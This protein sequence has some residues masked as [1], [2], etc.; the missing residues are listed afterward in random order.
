[1]VAID[2]ID[3]QAW[4]KGIFAN[5]AEPGRLATEAVGPALVAF[6]PEADP[7]TAVGLL[8]QTFRGAKSLAEEF[9]PTQIASGLWY[10]LEPSNSSYGLALGDSRVARE[11]RVDGIAATTSLYTDLFAPQLGAQRVSWDDGT[12]IA[13]LALTCHG[14]WNLMPLSPATTDC[15]DA[16]LDVMERALSLPNVPCIDSALIGLDLWCGA[17]RER[18]RDIVQRFLASAAHGDEETLRYANAILRSVQT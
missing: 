11:A 16:C 7:A 8:E 17:H 9:A 14:F 12:A 13:P 2:M 6:D 18:V 1:M 5:S 3:F 15:A 4:R 10:L